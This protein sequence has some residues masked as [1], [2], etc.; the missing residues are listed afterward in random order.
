MTREMTTEEDVKD[1][2]WG[3]GESMRE[4]FVENYHKTAQT[5]VAE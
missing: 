4:K 3:G 2:R 1:N 5:A